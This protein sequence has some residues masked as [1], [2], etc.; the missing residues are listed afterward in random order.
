MQV[1]PKIEYNQEDAGLTLDIPEDKSILHAE[2]SDIEDEADLVA[3]EKEQQQLEKP[4]GVTVS[5]SQVISSPG[6]LRHLRKND[7]LIAVGCMAAGV[8]S[9]VITYFAI[10]FM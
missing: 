7:R 3:V 4:Q 2:T 1:N 6:M 10:I 5:G 8:L 9:V